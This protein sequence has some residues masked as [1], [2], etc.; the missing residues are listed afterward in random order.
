M[1]KLQSVSERVSAQPAHTK[2]YTLCKVNDVDRLNRYYTLY[3]WQN[4]SRGLTPVQTSTCRSADA[5]KP[6][7]RINYITLMHRQCHFGKVKSSSCSST[8]TAAAA[9]LCYS[10]QKVLHNTW[11]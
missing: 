7:C 10:R 6:H 2:V 3:I 5:D 4:D 9:A 1:T 8:D 11:L